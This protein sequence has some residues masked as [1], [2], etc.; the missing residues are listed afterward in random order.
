MILPDVYV[1][2]DSSESALTTLSIA[3]RAGSSPVL[4][5]GPSGIGKTLVLQLLAKRESRTFPGVRYTSWLPPLAKDLSGYLL[6]LL[7]GRLPPRGRR[8]TD[9]AL[10]DS[11][12]DP[13][14]GRRLLL[15]DDLQRASEPT[16][17]KLAELVRAAKPALSLVVAGTALEDQR[18]LT[19]ALGANLSVLLPES[20]SELELSS[21]C[22]AFLQAVPEAVRARLDG[23]DR[24]ELLQAAEGR[25]GRLVLELLRRD[26]DKR[27]TLAAR[28]PAPPPAVV[29]VRREPIA[30]PRAEPLEELAA[31][32]EYKPEYEREYER[33][34]EP[35]YAPA[36]RATRRRLAAAFARSRVAA[37]H[38]AGALRVRGGRALRGGR[39]AVSLGASHSAVLARRESARLGE[40]AVSVGGELR[41]GSRQVAARTSVAA[42]ALERTLA[43]RVESGRATARAV[44]P[45][46]ARVARAS[47][48]PV[49]LLL[50]GL[51]TVSITPR[52]KLPAT[53]PVAPAA[54]PAVAAAPRAREP[55]A[56]PPPP[57]PVPAPVS[58]QINARPWARV[59]LDGKDLGATPLR[60]VLPA[61]FYKLEAQFPD[62]RRI[63]REIEIGPDH[64]FVSLR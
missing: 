59:W 40:R 63:R 43:A 23:V 6:Y 64:R 3:L 24:A 14:G 52:A 10:R 58:V 45:R 42:R 11:L 62:G 28:E 57:H 54:S 51:A 48:L 34:Y 2:V 1:P 44:R 41:K 16:V 39:A 17:R 26:L 8:A 25:P 47:L 9:T 37:R 7:F 27:L 55:A 56:L 35:E 18:A 15:V 13:Y 22:D 31:E 33:E 32:P 50:A 4:V 38:V 46:V 29:D 30:E 53:Q 49:A 19:D 5:S 12:L 36:P 20:L 61:G 21:L 60:R